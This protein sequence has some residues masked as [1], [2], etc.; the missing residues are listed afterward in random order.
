MKTH[1]SLKLRFQ[2]VTA[3]GGLV[4]TLILTS[5]MLRVEYKFSGFGDLIGNLK[6]LGPFDAFLSTSTLKGYLTLTLQ[7]RLEHVSKTKLIQLCDLFF[8]SQ[9]KLLTYRWLKS[10]FQSQS[11][12]IIMYTLQPR[13]SG[14]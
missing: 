14:T 2:A 3:I 9:I 5:D 11:F 8:S 6:V 4:C 1:A 12:G 13:Q 7:A 10:L